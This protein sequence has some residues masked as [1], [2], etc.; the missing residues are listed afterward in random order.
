MTQAERARRYRQA[1]YARINRS[2]RLRRM[3]L[4]KPGAG[5]LL[6]RL[7]QLDRTLP[8]L[9]L[10]RLASFHHVGPRLWGGNIQLFRQPGCPPQG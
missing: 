1:H 6:V 10:M 3:G 4:A 5:R 2:L 8:N 9:A 7:T